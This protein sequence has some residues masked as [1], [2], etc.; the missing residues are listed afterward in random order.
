M[1][2]V[3]Y[4]YC[5]C[6]ERSAKWML[7]VGCWMLRYQMRHHPLDQK[8]THQMLGRAAH[9]T[10][11]YRYV[12]V[13]STVLSAPQRRNCTRYTCTWYS[14]MVPV[15]YRDT[16]TVIYLCNDSTNCTVLYGTAPAVRT[17]S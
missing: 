10:R 14:S 15:Q 2:P 5:K 6:E 1:I 11:T 16:Y 9:R 12:P 4:R 3:R 7:V 13:L 8:W 17:V